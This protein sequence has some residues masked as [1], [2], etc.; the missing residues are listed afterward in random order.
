ML[1]IP[2]EDCQKIDLSFSGTIPE[3]EPRESLLFSVNLNNASSAVLSSSGEFPIHLSYHWYTTANELVVFDGFRSNLI[4]DLLPGSNRNCDI[5]VVTPDVEGDFILRLTLVQELI[6]WFDGINIYIDLKVHVSQYRR[7]WQPEDDESIVYGNIETL[8]RKKFK[9]Y[10]SFNNQCRPLMLHLETINICNLKCVIC[11][12]IKMTRKKE[13]M[14]M[15]L[16]A[17]IISDYSDMG[18]GDVALTPQTGDFWLDRHILERIKLLKITP[19]I[20]SIGF[21]TN[22]I[23]LGRLVDEELSF[24]INN[25]ERIT[26]SIYGLN[27]FEYVSMTRGTG[28]FEKMVSNIKRI[29]KINNTC[30][31]S[32]AFRLI[33]P[34]RDDEIK[35]WMRE[36]FDQEVPYATLINYGNWGGALDTSQPLPGEAKWDSEENAL[37]LEQGGPCAY[38]IYHLKVLVNGDVKFC[39]CVDYDNNPENTIGNVTQD[40][41]LNIYNGKAAKSIWMNGLKMCK[42]CTH[43]RPLAELEKLLIYFD[44]PI[45]DLGV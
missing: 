24:I 22:A 28:N 42:G 21:V 19:G 45:R 36:N 40:H 7:W 12:Y 33:H 10:L 9:P 18:G 5:Q 35:Q 41:L 3:C 4:E 14:S 15:D 25:C 23:S 13:T 2:L 26:I 6:R 34:Y 30:K 17:K 44:H 8:N 39:S 16:F 20:D 43:R 31:I 38:P 37:F 11:P 1:I 32:F 27:E 29:L